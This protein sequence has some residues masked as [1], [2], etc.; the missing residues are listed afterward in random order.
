HQQTPVSNEA[1]LVNI[2]GLLRRNR[3]RYVGVLATDPLDALFLVRFLRVSCPDTQL[4]IFSSDLLFA[5]V[6][7]N[8]SIEGLLSVTTYPLFLENQAYMEPHKPPRRITF[9]SAYAE[10]V[11]NATRGVLLQMEQGS[12]RNGVPCQISAGPDSG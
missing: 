6:V 7:H 2:A 9:P 11:Y 3:I 12:W 8:W 4:V 10:G 5:R 1:V